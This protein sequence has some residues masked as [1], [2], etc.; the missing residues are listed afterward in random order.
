MT[1]EDITDRALAADRRVDE[2]N[3]GNGNVDQ[4]DTSRQLLAKARY[5]GF[6]LMTES[7]EEAENIL[8]EARTEAAGIVAAA[9]I[10]AEAIA[11]KATARAQASVT[12]AT[13]EGAAIVARALRAAGEGATPVDSEELL[14][15]HRTLS[16]RVSTLRTLA[17]RLENRFA[18]LAATTSESPEAP[19]LDTT[20]QA[21]PAKN[22]TIDYSPIIEPEGVQ[23]NP[24]ELDDAGDAKDSFYSRRSANLPRLGEDNSESIV[25][26]TRA[27]RKSLDKD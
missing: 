24:E 19:G 20:S 25:S 26:M 3:T 5:D 21:A 6:K 17:D 12:A 10:S 23:A 2:A 22:Q 15:E 4:S 7:R 16:D 27:L 11:G 1:T 14:E 9:E 8:S 13:E 18:A